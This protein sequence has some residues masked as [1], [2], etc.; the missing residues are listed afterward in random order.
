M[1]TS[2]REWRR[3]RGAKDQAVGPGGG[4]D[5]GSLAGTPVP[6]LGVPGESVIAPA[7]PAPVEPAA[8]DPGCSAP[9]D[10][11]PPAV[12]PLT[13]P[14]Q[15]PVPRGAHGGPGAVLDRTPSTPASAWS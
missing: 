6:P 13:V 15:A 1:R 9:A 12:P 14:R 10:A 4:A 5:D 11:P 8:A 2:C 7:V 3:L